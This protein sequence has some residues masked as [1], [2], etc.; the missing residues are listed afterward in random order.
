MPKSKAYV[1]PPLLNVLDWTEPLCIQGQSPTDLNI[2]HIDVNWGG[3]NLMEPTYSSTDH[4][5]CEGWKEKSWMGPYIKFGVNPMPL[6]PSS[7][8]HKFN[9]FILKK[10]I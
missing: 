1:R 9:N 8:A 3:T 7:M 5:I 10:K 6:T 2:E 4:E